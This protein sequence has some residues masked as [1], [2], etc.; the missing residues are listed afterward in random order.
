[1]RRSS[2][3]P[4]LCRSG[5]VWRDLV[6]AYVNNPCESMISQHWW[7][8]KSVIG[9][10][11][12]H[13]V[14]GGVSACTSAD[15]PAVS[16]AIFMALMFCQLSL[17][18][19]WAG[20][21]RSHWLLRLGAF[22]AGT[23]GLAFLLGW[24]IGELR[25]PTVYIVGVIGG[26]VLVPA[27]VVRWLSGAIADEARPAADAPPRLQ[28]TIRQLLLL[29]LA[30]ACALTAGKWVIRLFEPY[31]R[32]ELPKLT[33]FALCFSTMAFPCLW[34]L[35]GCGHLARR[36]P[37]ALSL[38]GFVG[39]GPRYFLQSGTGENEFWLSVTLLQTTLVMLSLY[40]VRRCGYRLAPWRSRCINK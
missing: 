1:M 11:V 27:C 20:L 31:A 28:F 17:L 9:L 13:L 29:T 22:P 32:G 24:G 33:T 16:S 40:V 18:G 23:A 30:V 10:L 36:L 8:R 25:M 7:Q 2:P 35:L 4:R 39:Y 37:V 5:N 6:P 3:T 21:G 15:M 19:L 26:G 38:A 34:A 12:A 14:C